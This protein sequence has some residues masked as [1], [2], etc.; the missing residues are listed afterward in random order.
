[1]DQTTID[2]LNRVER[3]IA[4]CRL[5]MLGAK[6]AAERLK[7]SRMRKMYRMWRSRIILT[8]SG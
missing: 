4:E 8:L 7:Y 1:M 6:D 5:L 2:L 3:R